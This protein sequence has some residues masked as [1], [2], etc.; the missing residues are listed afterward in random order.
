MWRELKNARAH[1]KYAEAFLT[2]M[3]CEAVTA[4]DHMDVTNNEIYD[5]AFPMDK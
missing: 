1:I 2:D 4:L 5:T 3:Q